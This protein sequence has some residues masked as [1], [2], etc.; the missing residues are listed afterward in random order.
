MLNKYVLMLS[1]LLALSAATSSSA[2][3]PNDLELKAR[4]ATFL[5][6]L[7]VRF[8][9]S[10][11]HPLL[12]K[13]CARSGRSP[14]PPVIS[15][16][17]VPGVWAPDDFKS[18]L[19]NVRV[20]FFIQEISN[21]AVA[22]G[23]VQTTDLEPTFVNWITAGSAADAEKGGPYSW[24]LPGPGQTYDT[25]TAGVGSNG[26][27]I[28]DALV[29]NG[30]A[31]FSS[32]PVEHQATATEY[33]GNTIGSFMGVD[34]STIDA[35]GYYNLSYTIRAEDSA[36]GISDFHLRG[37]VSAICSGLNSL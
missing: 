34:D 29:L 36:G 26:L 24:P 21:A 15:G 20:S 5:Q 33:G 11:D 19:P 7:E 16:N 6:P 17:G 18:Y 1:I 25:S 9:L 28:Y 22:N 30:C 35:T 4:T 31:A 14:C 12:P 2:A 8:A 13:F 37:K 32:F 23:G 10:A 3:G 27:L